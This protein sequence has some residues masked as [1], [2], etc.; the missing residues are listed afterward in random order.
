MGAGNLHR[1]SVARRRLKGQTLFVAKAPDLSAYLA[2]N[3]ATRR[4]GP[5]G[6]PGVG[7]GSAVSRLRGLLGQVPSPASQGGDVG[8]GRGGVGLAHEAG[9]VFAVF[10]LDSADAEGRGNTC[11]ERSE[12]G[13]RDGPDFDVD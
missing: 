9:H 3:S 6:L 8:G 5:V 12:A 7:W 11:Y 13:R 10:Q 2:A 1:H 4:W